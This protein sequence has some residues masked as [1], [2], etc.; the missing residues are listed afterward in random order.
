MGMCGEK[1]KSKK[2]DGG[3]LVVTRLSFLESD[4]YVKNMPNRLKGECAKNQSR[5]TMS[6]KLECNEYYRRKLQ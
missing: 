5:N 2:Q 4:I 6:N 3:L 1:D